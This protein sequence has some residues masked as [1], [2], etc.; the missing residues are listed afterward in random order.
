MKERFEALLLRLAAWLLDRNV[1]RSRV[2]S[3]EDNNRIFVMPYDLRAIANRIEKGY[4]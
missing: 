2:I 4:E 1:Q 3:R